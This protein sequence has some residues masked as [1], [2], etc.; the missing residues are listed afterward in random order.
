MIA[1]D[2]IMLESQCAV[3]APLVVRNLGQKDLQD[4]SKNCDVKEEIF[5]NS[6]PWNRLSNEH[7]SIEALRTRLFV[8]KFRN[9]LKNANGHLKTLEKSVG[10]LN[11]F[12]EE[13]NLRLVT[14][15]T[16]RNTQFSDEFSTYGYIY[17]FKSHKH[18]D[19]SEIKLTALE[20]SLPSSVGAII[21][22]K[23]KN[24][25]SESLSLLR[26][27]LG[28][29]T[30]LYLNPRFRGIRHFPLDRKSLLGISWI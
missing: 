21:S 4:L 23:K 9:V 2:Q 18:E 12:D 27:Y 10:P 3:R 14:L 28:Y 1:V 19:D 20:T 26:R 15:V 11:A 17:S 24:N 29:S 22:G 30:R 13:P 8:L 6:P 16:N 7:Y 5:R 25:R